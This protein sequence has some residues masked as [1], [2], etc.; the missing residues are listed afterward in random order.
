M[1]V[2]EGDEWHVPQTN[3]TE[4]AELAETEMDQLQMVMML[5]WRPLGVTT[6]PCTCTCTSTSTL[7]VSKWAHSFKVWGFY[8]YIYKYIIFFWACLAKSKFYQ[9]PPWPSIMH[10]NIDIESIWPKFIDL[11]FHH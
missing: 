7:W 3:L 8:I 4:V 11:S 5:A 9:V 6:A 10:N 2:S 1:R